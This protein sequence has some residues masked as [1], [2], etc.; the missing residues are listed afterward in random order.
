MQTFLPYKGFKKTAKVLDD[1]RLFK[2]LVE[3]R[4]IIN[5]ITTGKTKSGRKYRGFTNHPVRFMWEGYPNSLKEYANEIL[6]EI[7]ERGKVKTSMRPLRFDQVTHPNW[8]GNR[9]FHSSHK[10]ALLKKDFSH[11]KKFNWKEKPKIAYIWPT[12]K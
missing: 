9:K 3:A 6:I 4:Q 11:Y 12:S 5:I 8:L 10:A 1:K 7:R 2:Q